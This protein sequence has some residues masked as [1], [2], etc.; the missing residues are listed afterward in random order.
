MQSGIFL[1][2]T[3]TA[4]VLSYSWANDLLYTLTGSEPPRRTEDP[5]GTG[6]E[7][8]RRGSQ[9]G[10]VRAARSMASVDLL[11]ARAQEQVPG[12]V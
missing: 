8:G 7:R 2:P 1:A 10:E 4:A 3:L 12:W 9:R 6:A 11:L 5:G